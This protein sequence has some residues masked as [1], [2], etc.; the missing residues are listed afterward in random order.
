RAARIAHRVDDLLGAPLA[1]VLDDDAGRGAEVGLQ[2]GVGAA[3][4]ADGDRHAGV[5]QAP[6]EGPLF[7]DELDLEAGQQDLVEHP[8]DQLVLTDGQTPHQRANRKLYA[9]SRA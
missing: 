5:V 3:R 1:V 9:F 2:P 6:G 8:D 7:D 4:V